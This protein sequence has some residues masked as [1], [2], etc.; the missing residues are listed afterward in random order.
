MFL[1]LPALLILPARSGRLFSFPDGT[2]ARLSAVT[3]GRQLRLFHGEHWQRP[4]YA[5]FHSK[6]PARFVGRESLW[7]SSFTNGSVGVVFTRFAPTGGLPASKST[8]LLLS[9]VNDAGAEQWCAQRGASVRTR[10]RAGQTVAV[11]EQILWEVPPS[12]RQEFR[13][14]LYQF[15]QRAKRSAFKEFKLENPFPLRPGRQSP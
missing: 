6:L 14:R 4:L 5:V 10:K 3:W 15:D 1:P 7:P 12:D 11:A 9:V 2:Q 8:S 13:V